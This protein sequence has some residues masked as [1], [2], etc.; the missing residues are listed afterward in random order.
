MFK[1]QLWKSNLMVNYKSL[2][3]LRFL[4]YYLI[5]QCHQ[6]QIWHE[7]IHYFDVSLERRT[8][9]SSMLAATSPF[10]LILLPLS[11][12]SLPIYLPF[13]LQALLSVSFP[14]SPSYSPSLFSSSCISFI[15]PS[16]PSASPY[17]HSL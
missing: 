15:L 3:S 1:F 12:T 9:K 17:Y 16:F 14:S 4:I 11:S 7:N 5:I 10:L 13:S 2:Y 8:G 6:E